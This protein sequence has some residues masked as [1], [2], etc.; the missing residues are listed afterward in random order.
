MF[1]GVVFDG[2][3]TG[4]ICAYI[5][6]LI[7]YYV[8]NYNTSFLKYL[9]CFRLSLNAIWRAESIWHTCP[10]KEPS[11]AAQEVWFASLCCRMVA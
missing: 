11:W 3:E 8:Y 9:C 1:T 5:R 10:S 7:Y 6:L 4:F 2:I